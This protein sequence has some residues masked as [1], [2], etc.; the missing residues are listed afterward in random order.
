MKKTFSIVCLFILSS[1]ILQAQ[2]W[3]VSGTGNDLNDGKSP[4]TAFRTLQK[5]AGYVMPGATVLIGNGHYSND[6]RASGSAVLSINSSGTKDAWITW[7]AAPGTKPEI[8]PGGWAGIQVT[9]SYHIIDGLTIIGGNDSIVLSKAQEDAKKPAADPH[10][11]TNGI[12]VNGRPKKPGEKPHHVIIKNCTVGKCPCGGIIAIETDYTTIEDCKVF[13]N[14]WFMRFG[15]SGI[16][17]LQN[18]AYDDASGYHNIIQ[19]NF[20]WDN[21]TMVMWEKV[22]RLSD[23]NGIIL[24]VT[25]QEQNGATN[26]NNDAVIKAADTAAR[27]AAAKPT[28]PEWKGRALVANNVCAFNGGSG[29]HTFRTKYVDIIN[30][31]TYHNGAMVGYPELFAN[32]S[33]DVVILNNIIIPRPGGKVTANNKNTR[34]RWDYNLSPMG[35]SFFESAHDIVADPLF[36]NAYRDRF[37]ADFRLKPGSPAINSGTNE[38]AQ[39]SDISGKQRP[40]GAGRDRGAFEQ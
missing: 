17:T 2:V 34:I 6:D 36:V 12:F 24:D 14:A 4:Q 15:G 26:M 39:P 27:A 8:N 5:A 20:C 1:T 9:G 38:L 30:N 28:R 37:T 19:R 11:N 33:E 3:H 13:E 18:W 25:D 35:Q 10:F 23:G 32:T 29:I 21:K 31:T 40:K 16:S 22:A 7:K